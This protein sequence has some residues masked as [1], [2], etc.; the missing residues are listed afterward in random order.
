[1]ITE[2][3]A[4]LDP[5][6]LHRIRALEMPAALPCWTR[7][8]RLPERVPDHVARLRAALAAGAA[9][10]LNGAAH[11]FKSASQNVVRPA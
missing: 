11:A 7:S 5:V 1:V 2:Q 3:D 4:V 8:W 9:G 6:A 10:E